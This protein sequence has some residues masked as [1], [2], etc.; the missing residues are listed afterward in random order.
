MN[1]NE[2]LESFLEGYEQGE[3]KD[4]GAYCRISLSGF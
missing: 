3:Q 2:I 4:I 1:Y